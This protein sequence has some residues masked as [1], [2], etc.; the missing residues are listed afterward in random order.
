M[1]C[2]RRRVTVALLSLVAVSAWADEPIPVLLG[3]IAPLWLAVITVGISFA[4]ISAVEA[5][6]LMWLL[7]LPWREALRL[8]AQANLVTTAVGA[9]FFLGVA[10]SVL[11]QA[12]I[13][14]MI[15]CL[16]RSQLLPR[17]SKERPLWYALALSPLYAAL[18]LG[19]LC[20]AVQSGVSALAIFGSLLPAGL[21][22]ALLEF[23]FIRSCA[24]KPNLFPAVLAAN[25]LSYLL[26]TALFW[27]VRLS[28]D[29]T[30]FADTWYMRNEAVA[31]VVRGDVP[32]AL[33]MVE[34][35]RDMNLRQTQPRGPFL[36]RRPPP[37]MANE[38]SAGYAPFNEQHIA[39]AL[40]DRGHRAEAVAIL[41][42]LAD[43]PGLGTFEPNVR[44][45]LASMEKMAAN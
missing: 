2:M 42:R 32:A 43:T 37:S 14:A 17:D 20:V 33:A 4:V 1:V 6:V 27:A 45:Q 36:S 21:L 44:A 26:L 29:E 30:P 10:P 39:Q 8:S 40:A 28:P 5:A 15:V 19:L 22:S 23:L 18:S 25:I 16:W 24:A 35:I 13:V 41:R 12:T 38:A 34:R 7:R 3:F 9:F 31:D 11:L